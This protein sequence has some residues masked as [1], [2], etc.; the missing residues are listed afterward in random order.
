MILIVQFFKKGE[1][2][3]G[4]VCTVM[5]FCCLPLGVPIALVLGWMKARAWQMLTF[6]TL[7]TALVVLVG[8]QIGG[9]AFW[10]YRFDVVVAGEMEPLRERGAAN[11][12]RLPE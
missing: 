1:V 9:A 6:M 4:I 2:S 5:G 11:D 8:A 10:R 12:K 7:W 3:F